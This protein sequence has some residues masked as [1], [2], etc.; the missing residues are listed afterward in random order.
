VIASTLRQCLVVTRVGI[1]TLHTRLGRSLVIVISMMCV[2]AVLLS[3]LSL[4]EGLSS[5]YRKGGD[6]RLMIVTSSRA[7][8]EYFSGVPR[9]AASTILNAP[10]IA[11]APDGSVLASAEVGMWIPS[12]DGT[13]GRGYR[14][15]GIGNSGAA[16]RPQFRIVDGRMFRSGARELIAGVGVQAVFGLKTGDS[17]ILQDGDW[18]VVGI[19]SAGGSIAESQ[20][21][22]DVDTVMSTMRRSTFNSM[23]VQLERAQAFEPFNQWLTEN[24]TLTV[25]PENQVAYY[26]RTETGTTLRFFESIAYI[27]SSVLAVGALFGVVKL[28]YSGVRARTREIATMRAMGYQAFPVAASVVIESIVLSLAGAILGAALAWL[29]FDGKLT[30]YYQSVFHLSVSLRLCLLGAGCA[31][32]LALLGGAMPAIRAARLPVTEALRA[33]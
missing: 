22:G 25:K 23:L 14:L 6:E 9:S 31:V 18:P 3:M 27:V 15:R 11:K 33:V 5:A 19:F 2:T 4:A 17:V 24:P 28:L 29:L 10:G 21:F 7:S 12:S 26:L 1:S 13:S 32:T 16:L 20:L 30:S 8:E